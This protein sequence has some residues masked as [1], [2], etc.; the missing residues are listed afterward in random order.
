MRLDEAIP[1]LIA[2]R[3][4]PLG[5]LKAQFP[6]P[7]LINKG[8]FG[9]SLESVLGLNPFSGSTDFLD[10]ELKTNKTRPDG[11]PRE[12]IAVCVISKL[13]SLGLFGPAD[14]AFDE[15]Y[16]FKKLANLLIVQ[17]V[18]E[19]L[20]GDWYVRA[21]YHVATKRSSTLMAVFADDYRLI[22][23]KV[24]GYLA[25]HAQTAL[26]TT[27]GRYLQ[28][29]PKDGKPY[30]PIHCPHHER[31]ISDKNFAFYLQTAFMSDVIRGAVLGAERVV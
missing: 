12:T 18:K 1:K 8:G 14:E 26:H 20:E 24:R 10:G 19:G 27:S 5:K 6:S 3:G 9:W 22:R 11:S 16:V 30:H 15:T 13:V 17:V 31:V 25:S 7:M 21:A 2:I 23:Q 28:I 29:R 4:V